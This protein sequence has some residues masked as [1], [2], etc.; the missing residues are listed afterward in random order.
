[1][2]LGKVV[3]PH[4]IR[5]DVRVH[6]HNPDSRVLEP[7]SPIRLRCGQA[8][9]PG[10]AGEGV[11]ILSVRYV[12]DAVLLKLSSIDTRDAAERLRGA[13]I[14]MQRADLPS[15]DEGE[16]YACDLVGAQVFGPDGPLGIV[17]EI[18]TY[19]STDVLVVELQARGSGSVEIPL[20]DDFIASVDL[21]QHL[22]Q[23][24]GAALSLLSP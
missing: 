12:P 20:V 15:L 7:G 19:P 23:V 3:R 2:A 1:M 11:R 13:T 10:E 17:R 18:A 16:Y 14:E 4:G 8:E 24:H 22:I 5:G 9:H 21:A 6:L